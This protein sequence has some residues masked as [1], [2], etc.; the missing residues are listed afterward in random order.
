MEVYRF[1]ELTVYALLRI[2]PFLLLMLYIFDGHFRFSKPLTAVFVIIIAVLRCF[3]SYIPYFDVSIVE[4]PNPGIMILVLLCL[5]LIK[6]HF[7]KSIFT[8]LMLANISGFTTTAAK[9]FEGILFPAEAVEF[10]RWTNSLT[11]VLVNIIIFIPLFLYVKHI[12][13]Q[14]LRQPIPNRLWCVLWLVPFT[15]Y[16]V[17]YRN[18]YF[19]EL[20]IEELSLTT[21][22]IVFCFLVCMGGMVIYTVVAYLID[23]RAENNRLREK[24]YLLTLQQTQYDN[25]Q[26]RIEEARIA[27]HD[28][29]QHLHIISA[30]LN[31]KKYGELEEYI[32]RYRES[33]PENNTIAYCDHYAVNALLQYFDGL[34][35][36]H[37]ISF[38]A[39]VNL[40]ADIGIQD[41]VLTVLLGN[42]LENAVFACQ[43]E[44]TPT[45]SVRGIIDANGVFFKITNTFTGKIKKI[46]DDTYVSSKHDG[47]GIG[48][49]SVKSIVDDHNGVMKI[50]N[51]NGLF[52][53]SVLLNIN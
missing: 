16:A 3:C 33:V 4:L 2:V 6:D 40:P 19:T 38:S 18:S 49:R 53:V 32:S 21:A 22:Y 35:S 25:L 34:S 47:E 24:E 51:K 30:Y 27:K 17:W 41:D 5:L 48:L 39:Q 9:Y 26:E 46:S 43:S 29:R 8:L 7:G 42:I 14:A 23:E 11:L 10:H 50:Y 31:D 52:T 44:Q 12:Y 45:I 36:K 15:L 20:N 13:I 1:V 28:M 37:G